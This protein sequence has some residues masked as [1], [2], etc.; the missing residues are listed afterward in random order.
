MTC[1]TIRG[2]MCPGQREACVVVVESIVGIPGRMTGKTRRAVV[3]VPRHSVV[4][5]IRFRIYVAGGAG[6]FG[7]IGRIGVA[8]HTLVPFTQVLPTVDGKVLAIMVK[9]RRCPRRFR[10]AGYAIIGELQCLVI[11]IH[12]LVIIRLVA[13]GTSIRCIVIVPIVAAR[14]IIGD[15]GMCPIQRIIIIVNGEGGWLPSRIRGMTGS[16]IRWNSQS[17][18]VWIG[19]LFKIHHVAGRTC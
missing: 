3:R 2:G 8:V 13:P 15:H 1:N 19:S 14:T 17:R 16:A 18:V 5:I 12:C 4:I 9:R 7:I 6:E 10:M 11:R